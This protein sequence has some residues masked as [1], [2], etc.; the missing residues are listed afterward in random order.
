MQFEDWHTHNSLCKHAVGTIEDYVKKA[1]ELNLNVIGV[2]DHFPYEYLSS[3]IPSLEDIPYEGYAMPTNNLESYILQLDELKEKYMNQIHIR[4]AFEIDFFKHQDHI[5]NKYLKGYLNKLDYILGSVHVLFGKAGVFAFDDGRFLNKYK[6]YDGND[7]IYMEYYDSLQVMI[8][9]PTFELDIVTHFD[10]PKKFDK[11]I[12]DKDMIMG[13]VNET[14]ELV[15]KHD[16][17]IEINTSGLRKKIKEQY[18]H[19]DIIKKIFELGI[20]ILLGSDAHK[21]E[22]VAYEFKNIAKML[23]NIGFNQFAHFEKRKRSYVDF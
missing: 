14:L 9:S 23:K 2:S 12:E 18:P 7:E 15:K 13:K 11:R 21:P 17:T 3:E 1:I 16:L 5:L 22:D 20:P 4:T 10:L 8:N 6:E 19:I